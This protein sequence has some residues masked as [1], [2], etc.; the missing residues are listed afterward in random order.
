[1]RVRVW[2]SMGTGLNKKASLSLSIK[3]HFWVSEVA[4]PGAHSLSASVGHSQKAGR[5][6]Y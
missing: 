6:T 2:A 3:N 5:K 1:M 4:D